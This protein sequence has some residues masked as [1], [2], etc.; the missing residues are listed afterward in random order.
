MEH[1][2]KAAPKFGKALLTAAPVTAAPA[3]AAP[4]RQMISR[5]RVTEGVKT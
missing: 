2:F 4:R 3:M 5:P 1:P